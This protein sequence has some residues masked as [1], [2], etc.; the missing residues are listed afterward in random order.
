MIFPRSFLF[1]PLLSGLCACTSAHDPSPGAY[2]EQSEEPAATPAVAD[3]AETAAQIAQYPGA[4]FEDR[5][6]NLWFTSVLEGVIRYDGKEF[7]N[8]TQKDGLASNMVRGML[9]DEKGL[10]WFATSGGVC[11]FDG[12]AF[13]TLIDYGDIPIVYGFAELGNHRDIWDL[14][15]D[16]QGTLWIATLDGVFR[17]EGTRFV[18]FPLP[19]S[20]KPKAFEFTPKMV[21]SI[22]EDRDGALWFSTDGSG[23]V[24]FDGNETTIF[25]VKEHGLCSDRICTVLQDKRGDYWFGTSDGGVSHYDGLKFST[26][27]RTEEFSIHSGWG[28]VLAIT[29]DRGGNLWFGMANAG[30]GVHRF[31]GET[32]RYFSEKDGLG[33]GGVTS[34]RE[35]KDGKLWFGTTSG[36]FHFDGERFV[37]FK[38]VHPT[39]A[40]DSE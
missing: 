8:F 36:V 23:A 15:R 19:V 2:G 29:E 9:E 39:G 32:S 38:R 27:M 6:G 22:F 5:Q 11:T 34:I 14:F 26:H 35:D 10:L 20:A 25:T 13:A 33:T 7:V 24:R 28:R 18:P 16:R 21:Y 12:E 31:D 37:N 3:N 30:G 17:L 1:L 40:L 4:P